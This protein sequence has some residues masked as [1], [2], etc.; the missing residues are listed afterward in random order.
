MADNYSVQIRLETL[1]ADSGIRDLNAGLSSA[2]E[3]GKK[4]VRGLTEAFGPLG[5][6]VKGVLASLAAYASIQGLKNMATNVVKTGADFEKMMLKVRANTQATEEEFERL[7]QVAI[8]LGAETE[9]S[10]S[11]AAEALNYLTM[12]GLSVDQAIKALPNTMDLATAGVIGMGQAA[13]IT[14]GILF[15]MGMG[16][17]ELGRVND[18]LVKT[19]TS[20]NQT[21]VD[22]GEAFKFA[23]PIAKSFGVEMETV[24]VLLGELANA[25]I[26]GE[27]GGTGL[28]GAFLDT[29]KVFREY[30][31]SA[32]DAEGK[33]KGL[34][35]AMQL[36][37]EKN[38]SPEE[39]TK[40]FGDRAGVAVLALMNTIR[41]DSEY[42]NNQVVDMTENAAGATEEA[43]GVIRQAF[44]VIV[45]QV[46]GAIE[47]IQIELF[48]DNADGLKRA[49]QGL[50]DSIRDN[51]SA[52]KAYGQNIM[53]AAGF[54]VQFLSA[55]VDVARFFKENTAGIVLMNGALSILAGILTAR[56]IGGFVRYIAH[57]KQAILAQAALA[58]QQRQSAAVEAAMAARLP[59]LTALVGQL[60]AMQ[61]AGTIT[62]QGHSVQMAL[63]TRQYGAAAV[64]AAT[65]AAAS[66]GAA[67]AAVTLGTAVRGLYLAIGGPAGLAMII[68]GALLTAYM[69]WGDSMDRA[70]EKL[71]EQNRALQDSVTAFKGH[72]QELAKAGKAL[73]EATD[74][75]AV[76]DAFRKQQE[77]LLGATKDTQMPEWFQGLEGAA[78]M[79]DFKKAY[80][81]VLDGL[82][83]STRDT[84]SASLKQ[85]FEI[86]GEKIDIQK[87][88]R[89]VERIRWLMQEFSWEIYPDFLDVDYDDW[90]ATLARHE[91][92]YARAMDAVNK[93]VQAKAATLRNSLAEAVNAGVMSLE[94]ADHE[95][96][97]FV[98][99]IQ[100]SFNE[101]G[102]SLDESTFAMAIN[103][104]SAQLE[105]VAEN[106]E[107]ANRAAADAAVFAASAVNE[108]FLALQRS[109][110]GLEGTKFFEASQIIQQAQKAT[111]S[112]KEEAEKWA[113]SIQEEIGHIEAR[114]AVGG[115]DA[116]ERARL[117]GELL[118]LNAALE[119]LEA[120]HQTAR[121]ELMADAEGK[122]AVLREQGLRDTEMTEDEKTGV[123][124]AAAKAYLAMEEEKE[125][126]AIRSA[127]SVQEA[128][129]SSC[130]SM[131]A[132]YRR[133]AEAG[134]VAGQA[135]AA[136]MGILEARRGGAEAEMA[137]LTAGLDK[138][139]KKFEQARAGLDRPAKASRRGGGGGGGGARAERDDSVELARV[140]AERAKWEAEQAVEDIKEA[141]RR[142]DAD[143]TAFLSQTV[144][145]RKQLYDADVTAAQAAAAKAAKGSALDQAKA[146]LELDKA[147]A[148]GAKSTEEAYK[149]VFDAI[150]AGYNELT[151]KIGSETQAV[152]L[153]V[154]MGFLSEGQGRDQMRGI[155]E[156][157]EP[158]LQEMIQ[159]M[160]D[161]KASAEAAGV[162]MD[163]T[164]PITDSKAALQQLKTPLNEI[165]NNI[166]G[167]IRNS[168][169]G[170]LTDIAGGAVTLGE[171]VRQFLLNIAQGLAEIAA[172]QIASGIMG[173]FGGG[174]G[175]GIGGF[176][177]GIFDAFAEGGRVTGPGTSTSDSI[178]ARLS[179][180][181][182]VI[183]ARA[184]KFWGP[185]FFDQLNRM[186]RFDPT[187]LIKGFAAGGIV[188]DAGDLAKSIVKSSSSFSRSMTS[189]EPQKVMVDVG[190]KAEVDKDR[191]I[192]VLVDH[193]S[194]SRGVQKSN[195]REKRNLS[196]ML[197]E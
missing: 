19:Y 23:G 170:M 39:V 141:F 178:L 78:S 110:E 63:L 62:A 52:L 116:A 22:L 80:R 88:L 6:A 118:T 67:T 46:G 184:V 81:E 171:A 193:P 143:V 4:E 122:I 26:R 15:G 144:S 71:R 169:T 155:I 54:A 146:R 188:G 195:T 120:D 82:G 44:D 69:S 150:L 175:G 94:Q 137:A 61:R 117:E 164:G 182:Y 191:L 148:K 91:G 149:E 133:L 157:N 131:I 73:A 127:I 124:T 96:T 24:A 36:L 97:A 83:K 35:Q 196:S 75:D 17:E 194:F 79:E 41:Q 140:A 72:F 8:R 189:M 173:L 99:M 56:L 181:E 101:Q 132:A 130:E 53:D 25:G 186:A 9:F 174:A 45:D 103:G 59:R 154:E 152:K 12:A 125:T 3:R 156:S 65:M 163:F 102:L 187:L 43:A 165:A 90:A 86:G 37:V 21:I 11:Q 160:E 108:A 74:R 138:A 112:I 28:R 109:A 185:A 92:L 126:S 179:T 64:S 18:I 142:G 40:I 48:R 119:E 10:A 192:R 161:L 84:I 76:E 93:D 121:A 87:E 129:I 111:Q 47:S 183:N 190:V 5:S 51:A 162:T 32:K 158:A 1:L 66:R 34:I 58:Q 7:N 107:R 70:T 57:L 29:S 166:N 151:R 85:G 16:V 177:A 145:A 55:M 172:Q 159:A 89:S 31:E 49:I 136:A 135:A 42:L 13:D 113:K 106:T 115:L 153:N 60:N 14:T 105:A 68:A 38:A 167:V 128:V 50:A 176:L 197:S 180:G 98:R 100:T 30:G 114:I 168:I 104:V 77:I 147:M 123:Y 134:L 139:Q 33:T 2:A 95:L 20:S 27:M